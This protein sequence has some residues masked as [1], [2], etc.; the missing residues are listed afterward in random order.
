MVC[1]GLWYLDSPVTWALDKMKQENYVYIENS[2][3]KSLYR[4]EKSERLAYS[5]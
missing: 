2:L 1:G 5:H 4:I 3:L